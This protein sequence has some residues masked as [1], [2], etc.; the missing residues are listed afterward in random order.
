MPV[1]VIIYQEIVI[2]LKAIKNICM[3]LDTKS[4]DGDGYSLLNP[5]HCLRPISREGD[6]FAFGS[7]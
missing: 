4:K 2:L 3:L 5:D 7:K 6:G 1:I